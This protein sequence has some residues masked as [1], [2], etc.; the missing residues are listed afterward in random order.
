MREILERLR[1]RFLERLEYELRFAMHAGLPA[2]IAWERALGEA[3]AWALWV[4][5][6]AWILR[7]SFGFTSSIS[8][9]PSRP[10]PARPTQS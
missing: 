4:P 3:V 5:R 7:N 10:P 1:E 8:G 2:S 9:R 6:E